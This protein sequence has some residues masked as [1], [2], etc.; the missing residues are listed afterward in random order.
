MGVVL[1]VVKIR[2]IEG[3]GESIVFGYFGFY[4]ICSYE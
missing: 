2:K 1:N 3:W 4:D